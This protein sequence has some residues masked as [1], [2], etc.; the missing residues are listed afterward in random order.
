VGGNYFEGE[1][2]TSGMMVANKPY[3]EFYDFY[4]ISSEY[5]VY[6]HVWIKYVNFQYTFM[7]VY[8]TII[9]IPLRVMNFT[10]VINF[11]ITGLKLLCTP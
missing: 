8:I 1:L 7:R 3:G 9:K 4:S 10:D 2:T 5:F 11:T 6:H